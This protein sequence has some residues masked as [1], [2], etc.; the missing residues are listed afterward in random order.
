[1]QLINCIMSFF[2]V[3]THC[4]RLSVTAKLDMDLTS[5][6]VPEIIH[7]RKI[8]LTR[9]NKQTEELKKTNVNGTHDVQIGRMTRRIS[10]L[11]LIEDVIRKVYA[12][13]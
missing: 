1:M 9:L 5:I 13:K 12:P 2:L 3:G 7:N 10:R 8:L 4:S 6:N 11:K